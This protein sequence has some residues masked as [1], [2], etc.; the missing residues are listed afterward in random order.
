MFDGASA[1]PANRKRLDRRRRRP[2]L[3]PAGRRGRSDAPAFRRRDRGRAA[4]RLDRLPVDGRRLWRPWR[5]AG[6]TRTTPPAPVSAR[7][8]ERLAAENAWLELGVR[9]GKPVHVFR[10]AGIYGPGRN[11]LAQ[12]AAGTARRIVKP[13]QVFNR[14]HVEDHRRRARGLDRAAARRRGLQPRRRRA[15]AAAGRRRVR[16]AASPASSRRPRS[17]FAEARLTRNGGELLGRVQARLE[18][19][20]QGRARRRAGAI[21][22]IA[23]AL[24]RSTPPARGRVPVR[25]RDGSR[26]A[27]NGRCSAG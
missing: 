23:K 17:P 24:R 26:P 18:P 19:P 9:A 13:G 6:S 11:A 3:D 12:L 5:R 7:S 10:L 25:R 16:G 22:P 14:I 1:D 4:S 8:R 27:R 2:G 21:R 15:G 20:H